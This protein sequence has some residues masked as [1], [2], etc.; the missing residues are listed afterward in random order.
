MDCIEEQKRE[1]KRVVKENAFQSKDFSNKSAKV[2]FG[3]L[4]DKPAQL[5]PKEKSHGRERRVG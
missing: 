1:L 4:S 2:V 5:K 3:V